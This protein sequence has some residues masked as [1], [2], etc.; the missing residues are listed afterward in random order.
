M[1]ESKLSTQANHIVGISDM[2]VSDDPQAS[3]VTYSLGSCVAVVVSDPS[4]TVGGLLHF[5][6]PTAS[7][8]D[9]RLINNP[10]KFSDTGIPLLLKEVYAKGA[11]R[12]Q[13]IVKLFGGANIMDK[14]K[15]F[16][17]GRRNYISAKRVLW[18]L[19][20][21]ITA[22]D[23]GG[24]SWRSISLKVGTGTVTVKNNAGEY[25]I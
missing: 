13:L 15:F 19:G 10:F 3:V 4:S 2:K 14:N 12:N 22:E 17:I 23:V 11:L 5:Q 16:N 1:K 24:T 6:L 9:S 25:Q 8:N 21:F 18:R 7:Q 20:Y